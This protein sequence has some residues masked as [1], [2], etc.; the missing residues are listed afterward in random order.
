MRAHIQTQHTSRFVSLWPYVALLGVILTLGAA[1]ASLFLQTN[2]VDTTLQVWE[3]EPETLESIP[4]RQGGLGAMRIDVVAQLPTNRWVT[5]EIQILDAQGSVLATGI[6]QAWDESGTWQEDGESG[7]WRESDLQGGLDIRA[8]KQDENITIALSILEYGTTA[9]VEVDEP[10]F[11]R[12]KV[13][14][15][16]IDSRYLWGSLLGTLGLTL[17]SFLSM[18]E[19]GRKAISMTIKDSD[20]NGRAVL[21]GSD[22][23]VRVVVDILADETSP[24]SLDVHLVIKD[25]DGKQ[26]YT[27]ISPVRLNVQ[28]DKKGA[29]EKTNGYLRKFFILEPK[30]SYGFYVEISPDAPVDVTSLTVRDGVRTLQGVELIHI[31]SI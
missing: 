14:Q 7:T 20:L 4:L 30:T 18:G 16:A 3:D 31:R 24:R 25:G 29:I 9:D 12:V 2:L 23:L 27:S 8:D 10:V 22:R 21:G 13:I 1:I 19:A 6:K 5:Y 28:R 11:F 26:V 17:L 15:G